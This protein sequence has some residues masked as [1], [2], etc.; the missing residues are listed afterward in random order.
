MAKIDKVQEVAVTKL[1]PYERNAKIHNAS[2]VD[3]IAASIQEFGFISPCLIDKN[4]NIIAGHGRVEACKTLGIEKVPCVFIEGLTEEQRRAYII[5]DNR[6][7][8]LGEWDMDLVNEELEALADAGFDIGL[9]GFDW[10]AAAEIEA[11]D[12]D[13]TP[14]FS[15]PEPKT[16]RGEIYQLGEHRLMCGDSTAPQE[17]AA[18][19]GGQVAD[20][21]VTDPPY[22]VALGQ[23]AGHAIRPSEAKQ[24]HRRTDGL[25]IENDSWADD[26]GFI[27]FLSKAF[28]NIKTSLKAGGAFYIWFASSQEMNFLRA[29]EISGLTIRQ[30]LIWVKNAFTLGRQDY[31]W[32][33]EPC[34][35]GWND[36][37]GHYFIER[38]N[39]KTIYE[40]DKP[41]VK[42]LS[43]EQMEEMLLRIFDE[44]QTQTTTLH[45]DKPAV[46]TLHPTMKPVPLFGRLINNS[47][48][49]GDVV[50][51]LFGGSGSTII[52][53]EQ[54]NRKC[55]M[56]EYDPHY[57]DVIID[58]WETFTGEKAVLV[59]G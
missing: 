45:E 21:V 55:Y 59:N 18:L 24:L 52:A 3:Q 40:T 6:L 8:E 29:C 16:K 48:R 12:D 10:D 32:N 1:I 34:L 17:V 30:T 27:D 13:Y 11:I 35:Y 47:S 44:E 56:M 38:R 15:V 26:D 31:Q 7:T 19:M 4:Y 28:D 25:V 51:D 37:A 41:D 22:N 20:L 2:Q 5:A 33:H 43:K 49:E 54:M 39:K 53:C 58:R 9:T 57:C 50:L 23:S 42:N 14:D 46:S 36:G